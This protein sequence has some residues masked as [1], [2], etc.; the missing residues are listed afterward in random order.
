MPEKRWLPLRSGTDL[1]QRVESNWRN[2]RDV[3]A[4]DLEE[5]LANDEPIPNDWYRRIDE[6]LEISE[7]FNN[8]L[9]AARTIEYET[10][11][12]IDWCELVCT[13]LERI[14]PK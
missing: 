12:K 5:M 13:V 3:T 7:G 8:I 2:C 6:A 11:G 14:G 9:R 4:E 1:F 10:D